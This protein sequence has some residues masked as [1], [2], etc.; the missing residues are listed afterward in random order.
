MPLPL[1]G[2]IDLSMVADLLGR[3]GSLISLNDPEVRL[4]AGITDPDAEITI[5]DLRGK[6][7]ESNYKIIPEEFPTESNHNGYWSA[8]SNTSDP[9]PPGSEVGSIEP[10]SGGIYKEGTEEECA[11]VYFRDR[12]ILS[13]YIIG[14]G[15]G[16][17]ES[18]RLVWEGN[19]TEGILARVEMYEWDSEVLEEQT[20]IQ[21]WDF[22]NGLIVGRCRS[23]WGS[24]YF[25]FTED[26][27]T[28]GGCLKGVSGTSCSGRSAS[29]GFNFDQTQPWRLRLVW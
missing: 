27:V 24:Y 8:Y 20:L 4:L 7:L 11:G 29:G 13:A 18:L 25:D 28:G 21:V 6:G 3:P 22:H 12:R 26:F 10:L 15:A 9:V 2:P 23:C 17:F 19:V 1:T 16:D 5:D 14:F